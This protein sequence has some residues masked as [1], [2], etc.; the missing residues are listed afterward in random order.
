MTCSQCR[1]VLPA[2]PGPGRRRTKCET[3][4]PKDTRD[5]RVTSAPAPQAC[6]VER[7]PG[8]VELATLADLR[9]A[10]R[11]DSVPG[12][13]ALRLARDLDSAALTGSQASSLG[14]QLLRTMDLAM[15][16]VPAAPDE[17]DEFT[18]RLQQKAA[19]A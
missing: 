12:A 6:D 10:G 2:Q 4:S 14:A 1:A 19:G 7:D 3:C 18:A 8:R 9:R 11:V 13:V 5:R 15:A 16:G 17:V